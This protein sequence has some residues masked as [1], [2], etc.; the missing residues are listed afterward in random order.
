MRL[1]VAVKRVIDYAV[2]IR[3]RPDKTGV[4]TKNVK[5]S[6]NPFCEIAVEECVRLKEKGV[7]K[8][9]VAVSIGDKKVV[10]T[11]RTAMAMGADRYGNKRPRMSMWRPAVVARD[12]GLTIAYRP[13][14]TRTH[15]RSRM[16]ALSRSRRETGPSTSRRTKQ[17]TSSRWRWRRS[18]EP[19]LNATVAWT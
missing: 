17:W 12:V 1:L 4:E 10:D 6:M 15:E 9:V 3:V 11:L 14:A 8:E 13:D 5:M 7:A 16:N 18:F 19:W 2:K